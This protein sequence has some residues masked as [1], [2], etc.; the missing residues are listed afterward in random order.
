MIRKSMFNFVLLAA[1]GAAASSLQAT[2]VLFAVTQTGSLYSVNQTTYVPTLVG[3]ISG[4][5]S[6]IG[7]AT[8][9]ISNNLYAF[10]RNT[11]NLLKIDST[12][13]SILTTTNLGMTAGTLNEGDLAFNPVAAGTGYIA[14]SA[15]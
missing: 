3:T 13:A 14:S 2:P 6:L 8:D 7:L 12:N 5:P 4:T 11:S 15:F 10:D 9:V 1:S